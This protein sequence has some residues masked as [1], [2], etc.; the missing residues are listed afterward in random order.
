MRVPFV[1]LL[2][3]IVAVAWP[4]QITIKGSP[5]LP[6]PNLVANPGLEQGTGDTPANWSFTTARPDNFETG[7]TAHGRSGKCLWIKAKTG[8][9][10]GY[11][12]Q[13]VPVQPGKSYLF[14]GFYRLAGGKILLY[15]H[16]SLALPDGRRVAVD[17]RFFRGTMRGHW[18]VPVF[19]PPDALGGPD[20]NAWF[21]FSLRVNVPDPMQSVSL[22]LGLYFTPGEAWFDDLWAGLAQT[23]LTISV[24]AAP[25]ETLKGVMVTRSNSDKPAFTSP[26]LAAGATSFDTVLKAQPTDERYTVTVML[27][28]GKTVQQSY[29]AAEV[30]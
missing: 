25:G 5:E 4:A 13:N 17:E 11:W 26:A 16:N 27:G 7:W 20:P 8:V 6:V 1:L 9:M 22:S 21:P 15:A 14:K 10:S 28:G 3:A 24:K 2:I 23:D 19:L 29:P 12:G 18:L 30:K